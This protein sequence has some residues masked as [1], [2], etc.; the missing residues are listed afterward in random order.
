MMTPSQTQLDQLAD[1]LLPQTPGFW[2]P[3]WGWL[4]VALGIFVGALG[5]W[6]LKHTRR[7]APWWLEAQRKLNTLKRRSQ[8]VQGNTEQ[9]ALIAQINQLLKQVALTCYNRPAVAT[10]QGEDW[11]VFLD[12]AFEHTQSQSTRGYGFRRGPG[13]IFS[14]APYQ[15][16]AELN[17]HLDW[18]ALFTLCETW[19][20]L[21]NRAYPKLKGM[22]G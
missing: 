16:Q 2:P 15:N 18:Q 21:Q 12:Q 7:K 14:Q 10:L 6:F 9:A 8:T 20:R 1:I 3:S 5:L 11:L 4:M 13:K 22:G 17:P 19:M